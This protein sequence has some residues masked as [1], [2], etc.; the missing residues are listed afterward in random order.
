MEETNNSYTKPTDT[1]V[2]TME[3]VGETTDATGPSEIPAIPD[4][5]NVPPIPVSSQTEA[6]MPEA[7]KDDRDDSGDIV[8]EADEDTV[9]Y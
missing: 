2:E 3:T 5:N 8:L 1:A 6:E 7:S 9:I 4:T